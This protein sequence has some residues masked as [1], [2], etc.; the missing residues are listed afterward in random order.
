MSVKWLYDARLGSSIWGD[1][2]MI[3]GTRMTSYG[4]GIAIIKYGPNITESDFLILFFWSEIG[5]SIFTFFY[6]EDGR[7]QGW[8]G[9]PCSNE[10]HNNTN[11]VRF[12]YFKYCD[13]MQFFNE[14]GISQKFQISLTW[15]L[16]IFPWLRLDDKI[17]LFQYHKYCDWTVL[18]QNFPCCWAPRIFIIQSFKAK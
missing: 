10:L 7:E 4:T 14:G 17:F 15:L 8:K 3:I 18:T 6:C 12:Q 5:C 13:R 2:R 9:G 11:S 1:Y 16:F